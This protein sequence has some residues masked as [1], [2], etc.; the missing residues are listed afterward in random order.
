N[1]LWLPLL[2]TD[3]ATERRQ[4]STEVGLSG[5]VG[6]SPE[7][8]DEVRVDNA[9]GIDLLDMSVMARA[10]W[11]PYPMRFGQDTAELA[12]DGDMMERR[13]DDRMEAGGLRKLFRERELVRGWTLGCL[14]GHGSLGTVR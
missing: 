14:G 11:T 6:W 12:V 4:K 3:E 13:E 2:S 5:G 1:R 7:W 10:S 9:D 8:R